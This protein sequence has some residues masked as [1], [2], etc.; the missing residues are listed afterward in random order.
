MKAGLRDGRF[1]FCYVKGFVNEYSVVE[2]AEAMRLFGLEAPTLAE[3]RLHL[4]LAPPLTCST[5]NLLSTL[6]AFL[7]PLL[8]V[9]AFQQHPSS[10]Q[11]SLSHL[12]ALL[13]CPQVSLHSIGDEA[14]QSVDEASYTQVQVLTPNTTPRVAA[15]SPPIFPTH[16]PHP[17]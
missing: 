1:L 13:L 12:L 5:S 9:A 11:P 16:L 3:V 2:R 14:C 6:L 8:Q 15:S 4:N 10:S 7:K 17:S